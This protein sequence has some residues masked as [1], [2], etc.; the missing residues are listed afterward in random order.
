MTRIDCI[1]ELTKQGQV[2]KHDPPGDGNYQFAAS[3]YALIDL[4]ICLLPDALR[5]EVQMPRKSKLSNL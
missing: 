5:V 4:D 2:V 1:E 3:Y